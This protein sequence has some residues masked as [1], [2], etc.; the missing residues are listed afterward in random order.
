MKKDNRCNPHA[1]STQ[2]KTLG[3]VHFNDRRYD[4]RQLSSLKGFIDDLF[5]HYSKILVVRVDFNY[6]KGIAETADFFAVAKQHLHKLLSRRRMNHHFQHCIGMAWKLEKA[7]SWHF[8]TVWFFNGH[9]VQK[10]VYHANCICE[11]WQSVTKDLGY[12]HNCNEHVKRY[13]SFN[14]GMVHRHDD[15]ARVR[16]LD[17]LAYLCKEEQAIGDSLPSKSRYFGRTSMKHLSIRSMHK[18]GAL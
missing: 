7:L 16:L 4:P 1:S 11:A 2:A 13:R 10:D 14:L 17:S 12:G 6:R 9:K 18:G 3:F 15:Q 5:D 8:H